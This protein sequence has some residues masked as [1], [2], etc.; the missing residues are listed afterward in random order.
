[1]NSTTQTKEIPKNSSIKP[2]VVVGAG[3]GGLSIAT[4]LVNDG[5]N[6]SVYEK[7]EQVGG[8]YGFYEIQKPHFG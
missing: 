4:L 5:H 3:V 1:M 6:V 7:S 2:V 8:A